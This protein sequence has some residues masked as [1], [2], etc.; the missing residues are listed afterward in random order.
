MLWGVYGSLSTLDGEPVTIV[1][2]PKSS[3]PDISAGRNLYDLSSPAFKGE[4]ASD[5]PS[6]YAF[7]LGLFVIDQ[8]QLRQLEVYGECLWSDELLGG[9]TQQGYPTKNAGSTQQKEQTIS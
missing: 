9:Y 7:L 3:V 2:L 8:I 6:I 1:M 4:P 5:G